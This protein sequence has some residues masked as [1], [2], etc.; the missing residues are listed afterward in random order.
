MFHPPAL[1]KT[2]FDVMNLT[3]LD[4]PTATTADIVGPIRETGNALGIERQLPQSRKGEVLLIANAGAYGR[5]MSSECNLRGFSEE[6]LIRKR[7]GGRS[8]PEV[9]PYQSAITITRSPVSESNC[10]IAR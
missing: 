2:H 10:T 9:L 3:R 7:K 8:R 6:T 1:H 4:E 5:V